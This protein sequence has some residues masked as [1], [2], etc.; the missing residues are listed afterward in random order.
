M[1]FIFVFNNNNMTE[2]AVSEAQFNKRNG[3]KDDKIFSKQKW[4]EK[5]FTY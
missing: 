3:K 1:H 5:P 4:K 2:K